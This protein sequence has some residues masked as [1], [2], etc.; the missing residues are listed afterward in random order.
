M[1]GARRRLSAVLTLLVAVIALSVFTAPASALLSRGHVFTG[2]FEGS[3]AQALSAPSGVAVNEASSEVY[4]VDPG[5]E[6]VERFKPVAGG[7]EVA[8]EFKVRSPGAIAI[9]NS[10]NPS[11]PSKGDVYVAAAEEKEALPEAERNYLY[12][13]TAAGEKIFKKNI[14]KARENKEEFETE[15]E[16]ISGLAVDATG[17]LWVYW[18][19]EGNISGFSDDEVNKLLPSLSKEEVLDQGLLVE[20]CP[21]AP[22]FAVA[23]NDE[24]FYVEHERPSP[25][26]ECPEQEGPKPTVVAKLNGAGV[27]LAR[28]VGEQNTTGVALDE[29]N[30]DVYADNGESVAAFSSEGAFVQR[31]GSGQLSGGGALALDS[32]DG[33]LY[34][35]EPAQDKVAI[36]EPEGAAQPMIDSVGAQN[37]TP[38]SERLNAQIDPHGADTTDYVQYG[39]STCL[40]DE[41]ACS[42]TPA[43]PGEDIG[44]GYG[45][46]AAHVPLDGLTPNTTYYYRVIAQNAHG[47]VSS[48]QTTQTFFT[49]LPSAEGVLAD[50]R[51][52]QLVSPAEKHG[53]AVEP[54]SREGA[55]IQA[56][57]NG[58]AITWAASAPVTGE[59]EGN[60]HP[61][62]VQVISHSTSEGWSS[63]DITTPHNRG[64]G[65]EPGEATEYR[66]FSPDLSL[67]LLQPQ[68]PSEPLEDPPLAPEAREKTIY[69]RDNGSGEFTPLVTARDD[70]AGTAFGGKL[71]FQGAATDLSHVVFS[72]EVPLLSSAL[73]AGLYEWESGVALKLV[74]VLPGSEQTPALEPELGYQ[75]RDVRGAIS[76]DGSRVFFSSEGEDGPLYL[77]DTAKGE[78]VQVNAARGEQV[79]EPDEEERSEGLDEVHFQAAS[80]DGSRVFFTDTWPL[81][82]ES[83]LEPGPEEEVTEGARARANGR[84]ADLYEFDVETGKLS[85]LT[86]DQHIGESADVLGTVP[87]TSEDGADVYFV[88]NGALTPN[89]EPGDCPRTRPLLPHPEAACNL[90]VSGPDP[91]H[92]E[93]HQ[94][95]LI[96]RLSYEDAPDWGG[97]NSP[98][99]GD[100]GGVTSQV[101][102]NGRYLAFMSDRELTGYDNVDSNPE[103]KGAHD[104]EVFLYDAEAGRLVCASCGP[105][106]H[107]PHGVFDAR[108]AGEGLG[109]VVDRP[110][111]WKGHWLAGSIPGWT[112]FELRNPMA[113]HQSRY[114]SDSGRLFFDSA[115][116][117]VPQVANPTREELIA[118]TTQSVGVENVY[119]YE[120]D[121]DGTCS[122]EPGC[123][124]LISSGTSGHES[125]FLDASESGNDVFFLTA[126]KL[127][128]QDAENA[129][130]VYDARVCGTSET[131]P[132]QA[133]TE[134]PPPACTGERCRVP[135]SQQ[136]GFPSPASSTYSGPASQ[137]KQ[138]VGSSGTTTKPKHLTQ[139][140]KLAAAL[141]TCRKLKRK[142]QRGVC[143]R[144]ARH[145][146]GPK[147]KPKK[148]QGKKATS[149]RSAG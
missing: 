116:A 7:Y 59:A 20:A 129:L 64:E 25:L 57:A 46:V 12:K 98:L 75:G 89:A 126:A 5:H 135:V 114:L 107:P 115:D 105:S 28:S 34:V 88:A 41:S 38:T 83:T 139:A 37:L 58:E 102:A 109:L 84:P 54:I 136:L 108:E 118:G 47:T 19:E 63:Q 120:P 4:V 6:R 68:V 50:H 13:F 128:A 99:P 93:Q 142:K 52:W 26:A 30:G 60:R 82:D 96:A 101:S 23:P 62:P 31:F 33:R 18:Y 148:K 24:A 43:P 137:A 11:D 87:G 106:G 29:T 111:T 90:Y 27:A 61:E 149:K 97:G 9:D 123:V 103:A 134:P 146:Y 32:A 16:D 78:T 117:L 74:S 94:T 143:E 113:E 133:I 140:Q 3:D 35:A 91:G 92:P 141:R 100:L 132:C 80:S 17:K 67:A 119:E 42:D 40:Q 121:G 8:G 122:G 76:S 77:R 79:R 53:A 130:A 69:R 73:E 70:T 15:L 112:L 95:R 71:E 2:T 138:Q 85:D 56:A 145:A 131:Q 86:P 147:A 55:L 65:I 45:D 127:V 124:A 48:P 1:R 72:S 49:T 39:T 22:G 81:S 21:A 36:F 104:E 10:S 66:F 14:F 144:R 51:Q 125:A 110:E 44:D